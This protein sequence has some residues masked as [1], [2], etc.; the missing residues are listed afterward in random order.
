[1]SNPEERDLDRQAAAE[2]KR[3]AMH[4][5]AQVGELSTLPC[6]LVSDLKEALDG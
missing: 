6:V 4:A 5:L 2:W 1:M 3:R